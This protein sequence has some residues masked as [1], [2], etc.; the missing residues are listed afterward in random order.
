MIQLNITMTTDAIMLFVK[1]TEY[2]NYHFN[3]FSDV[4]TSA[5]NERHSIDNSLHI[6]HKERSEST[7]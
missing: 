3:S 1:V 5:N 2:F 7:I 4:L 6:V